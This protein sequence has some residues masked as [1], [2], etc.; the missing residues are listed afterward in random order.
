MTRTTTTGR[1][2]TYAA[3]IKSP[4]WQARRTRALV[5]DEHR[6]S[7]CGSPDELHVRAGGT[8][9]E[10]T[11]VLLLRLRESARSVPAS[12]VAHTP[13]QTR[14]WRQDSREGGTWAA[15]TRRRD[16]LATALRIN[17]R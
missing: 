12:L 2:I 5:R 4:A 1:A 14:D 16:E 3:Y 17:G 15:N 7:G 10:I 11:D 6:C 8:L 9:A 13:R